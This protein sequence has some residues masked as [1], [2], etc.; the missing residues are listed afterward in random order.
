M[1]GQ[2]FYIFSK[3]SMSFPVKLFKCFTYHIRLNKRRVALKK[4]TFSKPHEN[5]AKIS[6]RETALIAPR[7]IWEQ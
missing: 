3:F 7:R 5:D 4:Q 2:I 1:M 6:S